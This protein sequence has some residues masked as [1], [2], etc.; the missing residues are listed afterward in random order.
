MRVSVFENF[1]NGPRIG[2]YFSQQKNRPVVRI[3]AT[4]QCEAS[5]QQTR[6]T[7]AAQSGDAQA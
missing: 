5:F 4:G 3:F 6:T 7:F 2:S 1:R